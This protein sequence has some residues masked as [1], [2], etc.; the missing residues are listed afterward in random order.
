MLVFITVPPTTIAQNW[1]RTLATYWT[2]PHQ[3]RQSSLEATSTL[4]NMFG[5]HHVI[6]IVNMPTRA[7]NHRP[8]CHQPPRSCQICPD[9][10]RFSNHHTVVVDA[11]IKLWL[12]KKPWRTVCQWTKTLNAWWQGCSHKR[13]C[14]LAQISRTSWKTFHRNSRKPQALSFLGGH[15][16]KEPLETAGQS[17]KKQKWTQYKGQD[18]QKALKIA[19]WEYINTTGQPWWSPIPFWEHIYGQHMEHLSMAPL[20]GEAFSPGAV[21]GLKSIIS[22]SP[23]CSP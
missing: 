7:E 11:D 9:H 23:W 19:R 3:A 10:P 20:R 17:I 13:Q 22:S 4:I 8:V 2:V 15:T 18:Y 1:R 12:S 5:D 21:T 16:K 6:L 14:A